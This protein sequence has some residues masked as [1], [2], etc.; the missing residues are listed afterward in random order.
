M[1]YLKLYESFED[2]HE[3]CKEHGIIDYTI[4]PD[5]SIDVDDTVYLG[6]RKLTKIPLKFNKINGDFSC[7]WNYLKTLEGSPIEVNGDFLCRNNYLTSFE[8][9]PKIIRGEF[10][11]D[12]NNIKSFE[13]FPSFIKKDFWCI[14]N[15]IYYIWNLFRDWTKI[16]LLNDFD[17]FRDEDTDEPVIIMD[18]LNDFLLTI[19]KDTVEYVY[20]YKNI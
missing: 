13:Y 3:I 1:R 4:N 18:R 14:D 7:S 19:G 16:E 15:P 17:I 2:I 5:G 10:D 20:G 9:S 11:C 12:N 8:Y 6:Y